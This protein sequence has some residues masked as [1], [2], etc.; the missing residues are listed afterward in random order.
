M[1][2]YN[3]DMCYVFQ[4]NKRGCD[5]N[6]LI[7]SPMPHWL[8]DL[9]ILLSLDS[10]DLSCHYAPDPLYQCGVPAREGVVP[11]KLGYGFFCGNNVGEDDAWVSSY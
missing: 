3:I 8:D 2:V 7:Y 1:Y 11:S 9:E 5:F 10:D 6:K 4:G